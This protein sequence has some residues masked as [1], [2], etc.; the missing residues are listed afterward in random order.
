MDILNAA[1][2]KSDST[3]KRH[4]QGTLVLVAKVISHKQSVT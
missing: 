4:S 1:I 3:T 2:N